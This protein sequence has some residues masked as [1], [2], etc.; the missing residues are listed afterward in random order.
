MKNFRW[1]GIALFLLSLFLYAPDVKAWTIASGKCGVYKSNISWALDHEGTL[2]ISG[3]GDMEDF[4]DPAPWISHFSDIKKVVIE[5]GV[6]NIGGHAF[7]SCG[8]IREAEI[9][10]TVTI[11]GEGA[12]TNCRLMKAVTI[13]SGVEVLGKSA[14]SSCRS[15]TEIIL[16]DTVTTIGDEAFAYCKRLESRS[17]PKNVN[18]IGKRVFRNCKN[19]KKITVDRNNKI[20][21]SRNNCN[22]IIHRDSNTLLAGCRG[23]VIPGSVTAIDDWAF[24]AS[25]IEEIKIPNSVKSIGENAFGMC[26][27]LTEIH[28]PKSTESIGTGAFI[29][30]DQLRN[31]TVDKDNPVYDSRSYCRAIIETR[32]NTL[33]AGCAETKIPYTVVHI[34]EN[35]FNGCGLKSILIPVRVKRIEDYAFDN[36]WD[37]EDIYYRGTKKQWKEI[38]FGVEGV[39]GS[40]IKE[41]KIHYN[42]IGRGAGYDGSAR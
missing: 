7:N 41:A 27:K 35:A 23:T 5:E 38:L 6:R 10:G 28:I 29:C 31:I 37:L 17:I 1:L 26:G 2:T 20:F 22:A 42:C 12:F 15:L 21:D 25:S 36:N 18:E 3:Y 8:L 11:I 16:P 24:F 4:E 33:I 14:F 40:C 34:E 30:C 9:A 19:L 13:A 39:A 32:K